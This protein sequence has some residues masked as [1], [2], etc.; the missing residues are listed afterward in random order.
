MKIQRNQER[1]NKMSHEISIQNGQAEIVCGQ[2]QTPWH[3][4]GT[5]VQ[6]LMTSREAL[7]LAHLDWTVKGMPVT[8]NGVRL[9]FPNGKTNDTW[10]GIC[11]EDNGACLGITGGR[12][13]PIQNTAAFDWFDAL[14]GQGEA[15]Y[16]TAGALRGG[17]QVWL[18]AK[19]DGITR[20]CGD[21]H[22]TFALLTNNHDGKGS[23]SCQWVTERV[24]CAN[25]MAIAL[26]GAKNIVSIRHTQ[27]HTD[28]M[29]Q[30]KTI[31]GM[32][33]KYFA[34]VKDALE[35]LGQSLLTPAQMSDFSKLLVPAQDE[36]EPSTRT[37]NIRNEIATLFERGAG[38]KGQTRWDALNAVTDYADHNATI[39]GQN[40]RLESALMGSGATL[41]QRAFDLLTSEDIMRELLNR[42]VATIA[43]NSASS[44]D[45]AALLAR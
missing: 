1:Q 37:A 7:Q 21:E 35:T 9:P 39:R 28:K 44:A 25:T 8:V 12:F 33:Q 2:N 23:L 43:Q 32:G 20:I 5:V 41:K 18:L 4:L 24:V 11:R 36:K 16:D 31:L 29:D 17:S 27:N 45:F 3:K 10:Q 13:T 38:N 22:R 14:I 6:G 30:A 40:T 34:T 19:V 15:V 26:S 42:P